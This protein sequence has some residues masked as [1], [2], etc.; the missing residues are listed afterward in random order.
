M[1]TPA[2]L[3]GT[4]S[5]DRESALPLHRQLFDAL[6]PG[7]THG[8]TATRHTSAS[9]RVMASDLGVA[10]NTVMAAFEQLVAEGYLQA[11]VG[12]GTTVTPITPDMLLNIAA[13]PT[14]S[15]A[16]G[17]RSCRCRPAAGYSPEP[18]V[19]FRI[20]VGAPSNRACRRLTNSRSVPG[21]G[22][23]CDTTADRL[24]IS[25]ATIRTADAKHSEPPSP[26]ISARHVGSIARR[27]RSSS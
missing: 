11:R 12:S 7:H 26:T 22:C 19:A 4:V 23:W 10:R 5:L 21:H 9:T 17:P 14:D 1:P 13:A 16:V 20:L 24:R 8:P 25:S 3:L 27:N 6:R 18:C 15:T 2:V